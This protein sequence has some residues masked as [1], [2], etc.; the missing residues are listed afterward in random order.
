MPFGDRRDAGWRLAERLR[1]LRDEDVVVLGLPRGGVPVAFEVARALDAPLDVIV[2]RRLGVAAHPELGMGA[3]GE[4][5]VRVIDDEVMWRT[6]VQPGELAEIERRERGELD[7]WAQLYRG[8]RARMDLS[9]RTAL[10]VDDGIASGSTAAVACRVARAQ[11]A[12]RVVLAVPV[13]PP[14]ALKRLRE[15]VDELVCLEAPEDF[16]E[17]GERYADFTPVSEAGV[18]ELLDLVS[19]AH[20]AARRAEPGETVRDA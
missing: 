20:P 6:G 12:A 16:R 8:N 11:G 2:V 18:V 1:H 9:G 13:G 19:Q 10:I 3:I 5:D 7:R 17:I 14:G 15:S 4:G